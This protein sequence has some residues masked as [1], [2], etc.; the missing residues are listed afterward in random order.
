MNCTI[1][2]LEHEHEDGSEEIFGVLMSI[3]CPVSSKN[4]EKD[5][6]EQ[7]SISLQSIMKRTLSM[8]RLVSKGYCRIH[9]K[10]DSTVADEYT[11]E[12]ASETRFMK[13]KGKI[14]KACRRFFG[15]QMN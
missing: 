4:L 6:L 13:K 2:Y 3:K 7:Q 9:H 5:P 11:A 1:Q 10:F 12:S 15:C 14:F 8:R